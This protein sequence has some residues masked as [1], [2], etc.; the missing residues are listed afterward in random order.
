VRVDGVRYEGL[1]GLAAAPPLPEPE[2][3]RAIASV[4]RAWVESKGSHAV[5]VHYRQSPDPEQ[6][7]ARLLERLAPI[8][9][10]SGRRVIEGKLTVELVP[11]GVPLKGGAVRR[12]LQEFDLRAAL[13]A[14][15]DTADLEA[16]EELERARVRGIDVVRVAVR[17]AETPPALI[18]A[19]DEVADSPEGLVELLRGL[20]PTPR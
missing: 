3:E 2:V 8:A 17:G 14:G 9:A 15:D 13:Y 6:A 1:Y 18:E 20:L 5:S 10:A 16:F 4:P 11:D 19:A 7:R 12:L